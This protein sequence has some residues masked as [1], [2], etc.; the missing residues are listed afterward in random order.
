MVGPPP[1]V[2]QANTCIAAVLALTWSTFLGLASL[3]GL[4]LSTV[5]GRGRS[6]GEW[7]TRGWGRIRGGGGGGRG[8]VF[9]FGCIRLQVC[10]RSGRVELGLQLAVGDACKSG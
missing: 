6:Q 4:E 9:D 10:R 1:L 5:A 8:E 3:R 7:R 2:R